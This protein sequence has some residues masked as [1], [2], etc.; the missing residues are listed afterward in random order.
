[1]ARQFAQALGVDLQHLEN[2]IID[3]SRRGEPHG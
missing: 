3:S 1:M 2:R